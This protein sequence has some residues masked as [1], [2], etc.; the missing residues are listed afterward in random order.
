MTD[1]EV[2]DQSAAEGFELEERVCR[3][4]VEQSGEPVGCATHQIAHGMMLL[5]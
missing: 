3:D 4:T 5:T 1:D 2:L